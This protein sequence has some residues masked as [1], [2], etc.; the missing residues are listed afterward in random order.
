[1]KDVPDGMVEHINARA[2]S[3]LKGES[4]DLTRSQI[5]AEMIVMGLV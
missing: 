4:D 1:M 5:Q 2:I 3:A